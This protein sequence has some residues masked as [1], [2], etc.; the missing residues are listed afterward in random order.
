MALT[1]AEQKRL[2]RLN[3]KAANGTITDAELKTRNTLRRKKIGSDKPLSTR[4]V[5]VSTGPLY[6]GVEAGSDLEQRGLPLRRG[7]DPAA[8]TGPASF[9]YTSRVKPRYK[10]GYLNSKEFAAEL[11]DMDKDVIES[12]QGAFYDLGLLKKFTPGKMDK[13]TRQLFKDL[14]TTAN[15]EGKRWQDVFMETLETGTVGYVDDGPSQ[16]RAPFVAELDDPISL[17]EAFQRVAADIY[18]GDLPDSEVNAMVDA[19]RSIQMERQK[20]YYDTQEVGGTADVEPDPGAFAAE[21]IKAAHPDQAARV[22]FQ[23]TLGTIMSTF[24]NSAPV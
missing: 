18:G 9:G 22:K 11:G 21:R 12:Y 8:T 23:D 14:I 17:R 10:V 19:Y 13:A 15:Q 5:T 7:A 16:E 2:N 24:S 6:I 4:R 3:K 20:A 1:A